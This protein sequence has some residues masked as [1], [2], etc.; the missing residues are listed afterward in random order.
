MCICTM[1]VNIF[2]KILIH[3]I[4]WFLQLTVVGRNPPSF[5]LMEG[6]CTFRVTIIDINDNPPT[7]SQ[8][9]YTIPLSFSTTPPYVSILLYLFITF[10]RVIG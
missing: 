1:I 6:R 7:F 3:L 9:L 4:V 5:P 8:A 10:E 2:A